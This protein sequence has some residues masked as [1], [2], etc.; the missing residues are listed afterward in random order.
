MGLVG[1]CAVTVTACKVTVR[2]PDY[3]VL[4]YK[5][6]TRACTVGSCQLQFV[7]PCIRSA[8]RLDED[9]EASEA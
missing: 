4:N 8:E 9:D 3:L 6:C 5:S 7:G 2:G 1:R